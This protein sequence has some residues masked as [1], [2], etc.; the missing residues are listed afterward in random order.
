MTEFEPYRQRDCLLIVDAMRKTI[1]AHTTSD[2]CVSPHG[3][4]VLRALFDGL[5]IKLGGERRG[6][7]GVPSR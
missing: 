5:E 6:P 1:E 7:V 3:L 2:G 4:T